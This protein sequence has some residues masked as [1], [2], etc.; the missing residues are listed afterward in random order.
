MSTYPKCHCV[1]ETTGGNCLGISWRCVS[2]TIFVLDA[3]GS[4]TNNTTNSC[5][6]SAW[7]LQPTPRWKAE[8]VESHQTSWNICGTIR[9]QKQAPPFPPVRQAKEAWGS[10][11]EGWPPHPGVTMCDKHLPHFF[12]ITYGDMLEIYIYYYYHFCHYY[13]YHYTIAIVTRNIII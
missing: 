3:T 9:P 1:T 5:I 6:V 2:E 13:Y 10:L 12:H 7:Q 8:S 11:A 4:C